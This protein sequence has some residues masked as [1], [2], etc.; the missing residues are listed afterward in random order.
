MLM[1][2]IINSEE[3]LSLMDVLKKSYKFITKQCICKNFPS[4]VIFVLISIIHVFVNTN[5]GLHEGSNQGSKKEN[6]KFSDINGKDFLSFQLSK[7]LL[8][9]N[10]A[11]IC[12]TNFFHSCFNLLYYT[13][14]FGHG[15]GFNNFKS[16]EDYMQRQYVRVY[17]EN[18]KNNRCASARI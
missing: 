13:T 11:V 7:V 1:K 8:L 15:N 5:L 14:G 10:F 9:Q 17:Y 18:V 4:N 2:I 12:I 16:Y 3:I 6:A